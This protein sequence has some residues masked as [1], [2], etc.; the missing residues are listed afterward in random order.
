[1]PFLGEPGEVLDFTIGRQ[2][3]TATFDSL[4]SGMQENVSTARRRALRLVEM[5]MPMGD[6]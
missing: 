5:S 3:Y 6:A 1:M 4:D 2:Q